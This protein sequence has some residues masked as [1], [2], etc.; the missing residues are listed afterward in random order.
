MKNYLISLLI[1]TSGG[2]NESKP[3]PPANSINAI[4]LAKDTA[5]N[6]LSNLDFAVK[7]DLVCGMPLRAGLSDTVTYKNKLYGFCAP[8]CKE[9]FLKSPQEYLATEGKK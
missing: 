6:N 8:G 7:K 3:I 5:I 9:E 2:C 4:V 1:I